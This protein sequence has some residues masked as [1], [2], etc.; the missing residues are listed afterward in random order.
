MA[1]LLCS[2]TDHVK[3]LFFLVVYLPSPPFFYCLSLVGFSLTSHVPT[4]PPIITNT[5]PPAHTPKTQTIS[6]L[7]LQEV[8]WWGV[9]VAAESVHT[10]TKDALPRACQ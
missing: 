10:S 3:T 8:G 7:D 5:L 2:A 9:K 1:F 4:H 6:Q